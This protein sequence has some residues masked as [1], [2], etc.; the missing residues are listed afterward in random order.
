MKILG[1]GTEGGSVTRFAAVTIIY[2]I[3]CKLGHTYAI[4]NPVVPAVSPA[5][6]VALSVFL[7]YGRRIW[8]AIAL[9]AFLANV[10]T[11]GAVLSSAGMALGSS[12]EGYLAALLTERFANGVNA[13][14]R[15][16][17]I[18]NF[19]I[20]GPL[21]STMVAATIGVASIC[22]NGQA[23]W[24]AFRAMWLTWWVGDMVGMLIVT[25]L[26]T[27]WSYSRR[28]RWKFWQ[29]VEGVLLLIGL[30]L[31][32]FAVFGGMLPAQIEHY[33]FEIIN[34]PIIIWAA[35]RFD[36]R[37]IATGTFVLSGIAVWGTLQGY[38]PFSRGSQN[39]SLLLVQV[40]A[41]ITALMAIVAGAVVSERRK[42]TQELEEA[43]AHVKTLKGLLPICAWCKRIRNDGGYWEEVEAYIHGHADVDFSHG[44]CPDCMIRYK[45]DALKRKKKV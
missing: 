36:Q 29:V 15:A 4:L 41:G 24:S 39:D 44:I 40:F 1:F 23:A 19:T 14:D 13:F 3:T 5:A 9:G 30:V 28:W 37:E 45:A 21:I 32:G 43:L 42:L 22:L 26:V 20:V 6:G 27:L 17:D 16:G 38:G 33:P 18:L 35:L 34:I 10:T 31:F 7:I 2:A 12:I 25:P 8:P 11:T